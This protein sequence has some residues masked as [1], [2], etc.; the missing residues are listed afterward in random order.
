MSPTAAVNLQD[1][2]FEYKAGHPILQ[3][4]NFQVPSG[5]RVFLHGPSGSGKT[6]LL[7]LISGILVPQQGHVNVLGKDLTQLS[8]AARDSLR[9][10][11]IGYIFQGFNLIPYL[12]VAENIALPCDLHS[13]R[14]AR[15]SEPTIAK[16]VARLARRLEIHTHLNAPVTELST[17]QQQRVAI[18]RA[19]IG[20]PELVI[21]DEPTSSLDTDRRD[22]FLDLLTE[23]IRDTKNSGQGEVTLM[24]VSHDRSLAAH[25]DQTVS[26]AEINHAAVLAEAKL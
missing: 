18:A 24:F 12:T 17:G 21:A 26:L 15:I 25:F 11:Q 16:E 10:S 2:R 19:I 4:D 14:R 20:S 9:G 6:T 1:V 3:I 5:G 7:S 22:A 8:A 13:A 23:A